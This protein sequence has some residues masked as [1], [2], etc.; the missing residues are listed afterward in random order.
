MQITLKRYQRAL[1]ALLSTLLLSLGW[2]RV[3]GLPLLVAF[4]P[5]LLISA[6]YGDSRKEWWRMAGWVALVMGA[7]C[8]ATCWWIYYAAAVGI[9]AATLIQML[10]FG[11]VFMVFHTFSKK[12]R[13]VTETELKLSSCRLALGRAP[14]P[15]RRDFVPLV[16]IGQ[17]LCGR[18]VGYSVV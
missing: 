9:I 1:L 14:L 17:W 10:L 13:K 7:W 2:L 4:V 3:S 5:L 11:G 16:G 15:P 6:S 18:C 8:V 12:A